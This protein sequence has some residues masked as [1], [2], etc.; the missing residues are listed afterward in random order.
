MQAFFDNNVHARF[1][2]PKIN[3]SIIRDGWTGDVMIKELDYSTTTFRVTKDK[4][5]NRAENCLYE[6][7]V[8][9]SEIVKNCYYRPSILNLSGDSSGKLLIQSQWF[10]LETKELPQADLITNQ[11]DLTVIAKSAENLI[12]ADTNGFS[13]PYLKFYLNDEEDPIFKTHVEKKTLNPTWNESHTFE[14]N[15]RVMDTLFVKVMDWDAT[16]GDDY[17]GCGKIRLCDV[18]PYKTTSIDLP[19]VL[20]GKDGGVVH[21]DF[22]YKPKYIIN[23]SKRE[24]KVGDVAVKGLGTGIR[25][26]TTV[27]ST[28]VGTVGKIGKGILGVTGLRKSKKKDE[29]PSA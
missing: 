26:G 29:E 20:E 25:A 13:D 17:I 12:S 14:I 18:A 3:S 22:E 19:I 28:G 15:N 8:P 7:T 27:V 9:T 21:L 16:S 2:S 11:G 5:A 4:N 6:V 1:V 24:T 10:P 23:V